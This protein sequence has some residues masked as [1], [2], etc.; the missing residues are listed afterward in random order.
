MG[1]DRP[2]ATSSSSVRATRPL[3]YTET[4]AGP[5]VVLLHGLT[6]NSAYWLRVVSL[7]PG[8]RVIAL[9][10]G[11]HGLSEHRKSY[12]YADYERDLLSLLDELGLDRVSVAGHSLGG[13]VAL[14]AATRSDRIAAV[15]AMD[16]KSDWTDADAELADRSRSA[17]QRIEPGRDALV[18]RLA[19]TLQPVTLSA[20]E[21]DVVAERSLE[22]VGEG[23]RFRWDRRVLAT[24]PVDPFA[25]LSVVRCPVHV[26]AGVESDVMPRE[27]AERFAAAIPGATL[28]LVDGVGHHVELEAP[29]RVA[30][31]ALD[32]V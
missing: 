15:L 32:L 9:D 16:V 18:G 14:L 13:Y 1:I 28:E 5:P 24:E 25:F 10:F 7:L 17:E 22:Q 29:E 27:A 31:R 19:R 8:R 30:A 21:L 26:L 2:R 23:W 3:A 4:G 6:C 12:A 11:G 20:D